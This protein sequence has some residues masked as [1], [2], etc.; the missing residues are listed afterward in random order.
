MMNETRLFSQSKPMM[1]LSALKT[2]AEA[3]PEIAT[4]ELSSW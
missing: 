1:T 4:I 2:R 3:E